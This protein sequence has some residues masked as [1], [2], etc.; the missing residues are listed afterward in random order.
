MIDSRFQLIYITTPHFWKGEADAINRLMD[1]QDFV[2]HLRKPNAT[3]NEVTTLL[4][5]ILPMFYARI[6]LHEHFHLCADFQLRGAHL[7]SRCNVLPDGFSGTV[8]RSCHSLEELEI[9]NKQNFN[10][11]TLSPI[12]DSISKKGYAS[13]FTVEELKKAANDGIINHKTIAL[14]GVTTNRLPILKDIGF[15][16][17]AL[18]GDVWKK[19]NTL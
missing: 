17:A 7:N 8:S 13:N 6:V 1:E 4:N 3:E 16:G 12:F 11:L 15:G 2:L 10:Y 18:L 19:W 14:G 9:Y 5:Q